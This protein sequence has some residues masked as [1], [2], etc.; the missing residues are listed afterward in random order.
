MKIHEYGSTVVTAM[1]VFKVNTLNICELT[2]EK[3]VHQNMTK[4]LREMT[5]HNVEK[6]SV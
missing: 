3:Q 5:K 6:S 1:T 2:L 4:K